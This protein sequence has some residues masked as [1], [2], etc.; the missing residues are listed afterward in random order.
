MTATNIPI[1][2]KRFQQNIAFYIVLTFLHSFY[3]VESFRKLSDNVPSFNAFRLEVANNAFC[4][5][6]R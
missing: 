1:S 2:D 5:I 6:K 4:A 3:N